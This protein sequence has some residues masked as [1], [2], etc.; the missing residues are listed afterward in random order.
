MSE[1][2]AWIAEACVDP[3]LGGS[4]L[5][6]PYLAFFRERYGEKLAAVIFYGSCLSEATRSSTSTPDFF[7]VT[8]DGEV[9]A[10]SRLTRALHGYVPPAS[11]SADLGGGRLF[12]Y[13]YLDLAQLA[14]LTGPAM[15]DLFAAGRLSK[16]VKVVHHADEETRAQVCRALAS[17][18]LSLV[19]LACADLGERPFSLEEYVRAAVGISYQSEFRIEV[20]GKVQALVGAF[21][22]YYRELHGRV[23]ALAVAR[24]ELAREGDRFRHLEPAARAQAGRFLAASRRRALLRWPKVLLTMEHWGEVVLQ[25]V[26]RANP[27]LRFPEAPRR[28]PLL[29]ALP[30]LVI[31][32]SRGYISTH[33]S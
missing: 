25:K 29:F 12:K 30:Y 16:R 15:P 22:D 7:V 20:P 10:H 26:E 28:H 8:R 2:E 1:L 3:A 13:V 27:G 21:P 11:Q 5:V 6:A 31:F 23:L 24:G 32:L 4:E 14:Y 9:P 17:A 19:P 33:R 18:A